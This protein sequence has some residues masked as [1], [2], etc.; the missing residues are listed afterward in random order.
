[1]TASGGREARATG[2]GGDSAKHAENAPSTTRA[3]NG[4]DDS[5]AHTQ[6]KQSTNLPFTGANVAIVVLIGLFMLLLGVGLR[7]RLVR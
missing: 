7:I 4:A 5:T 6:D 3:F 2:G 1:L